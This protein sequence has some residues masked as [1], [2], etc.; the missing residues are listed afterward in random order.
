MGIIVRTACLDRSKT[1]LQKDVNYLLNLWKKIEDDYALATAPA[2]IYSEN[3]VVLRSIRDYFST[4]MK[5]ILIDDE[6]TF[7]KAVTFMKSVMPRY[8]NILKLYHES[9]P[10]FT[11]YELEKQIQAIYSRKAKL[12][13]GGHLAIDTT[14]AMVVI[15]VNSGQASSGKDMEDTAFRT[16]LE[17]AL[18]IG[19]QLVLR[20]LAG[21]VVI[22]FIDMR[23]KD[24]IKKV[25]KA[26]KDALKDDK[27][28]NRLG[29]I[30]QFGIM[31]LSRERLSPPI[32]EKSHVQCPCCFGTG[33]VRSAESS[34][35]MALREIHLY[36][37]RNKSSVIN[38]TLP[39]NIAF[40][41][42]NKYRR[43][44]TKLEQDYSAQINII[45]SQTMK[46]DEVNIEP[47]LIEQ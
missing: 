19:R 24:N 4:D 27:A 43:H 37:D 10:L 8:K 3:D 47:I 33:I 44:L 39:K 14:E 20:D 17:A 46:T 30:S 15:D 22:D 11:K 9:R 13:S 26:V 42:L 45:D 1:D 38:V 16:N 34:S 7:K 29:K 35:L 6:S 5:E 12:K 32:L 31:E 2:Q 28:H 23:S 40:S 36:L 25:E 41:L 21:L 18:E